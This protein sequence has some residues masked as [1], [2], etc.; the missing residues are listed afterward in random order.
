VFIFIN[1]KKLLFLLSVIFFT[2]CEKEEI[3]CD[4]SFHSH[5]LFVKDTLEYVKVFDIDSGHILYQDSNVYPQFKVVDDSYLQIMGVNSQA[6][7]N[8]NF[9]YVN[10]TVYKRVSPICIY[11][12]N[13]HV[14]FNYPSDTLW[15]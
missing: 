10:D 8:I 12:D 15:L 3:I 11:T 4:T 6:A 13:C 7:L 2:S 14:N 5:Y 9:R 1:M